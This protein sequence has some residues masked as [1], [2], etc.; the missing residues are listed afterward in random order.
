ML[1]YI[2]YFNVP[3]GWNTIVNQSCAI[4]HLG[5]W[6]EL[7]KKYNVLVETLDLGDGDSNSHSVMKLMGWFIQY[8][9]QPILLACAIVFGTKLRKTSTMMSW[10]VRQMAKYTSSYDLFHKLVNSL[11]PTFWIAPGIYRHNGIFQQGA[12]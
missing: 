1:L 10:V 8:L 7:K 4:V 6:W 2:K 5:H 3:D 12:I 11:N 9:S